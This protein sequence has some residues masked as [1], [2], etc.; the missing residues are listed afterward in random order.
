MTRNLESR[1][2]VVTPVEDPSLRA[3]LRQILDLQLGDQRN[4]WEMRSDGSY[5]QRDGDAAAVGS[6]QALVAA[7]EARH[8]EATRLRKRRPQTIARRSFTGR[9]L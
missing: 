6:Q 9:P 5:V 4:A 8:H 2:E 3:E 7:A 1:V